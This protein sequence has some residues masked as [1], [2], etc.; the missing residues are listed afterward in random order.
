LNPGPT[1]YECDRI[2]HDRLKIGR[3]VRGSLTLADPAEQRFSLLCATNVP[4]DFEAA[5][6]PEAA[7]LGRD[8][9]V[10][11]SGIEPGQS[12]EWHLEADGSTAEHAV[13][14]WLLHDDGGRHGVIK[15]RLG[16]DLWR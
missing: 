8:G 2:P 13:R 1:D 4:Q 7:S 14:V 15:V 12:G 16:A 5:R 3:F 11:H 10:Q 9:G 6:F